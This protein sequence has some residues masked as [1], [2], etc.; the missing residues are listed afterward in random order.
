MLTDE[1]GAKVISAERR[2]KKKKTK[3]FFIR[4][5]D[6]GRKKKSCIGQTGLENPEIIL[7]LSFFLFY[8]R[9]AGARLVWGTDR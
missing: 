6:E 2:H 4:I 1:L 9:Y 3:Y 8:W 5:R 7:V